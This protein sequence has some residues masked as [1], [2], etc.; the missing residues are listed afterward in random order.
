MTKH[1]IVRRTRRQAYQ[2]WIKALRGGKYRKDVDILKSRHGYCCLGVLCDL[3]TKDGGPKW[4]V[5]WEVDDVGL[6]APMRRFMGMTEVQMNTLANMNDGAGHYLHHPHSFKE[7]A[8]YIET[9]LL[10]KVKD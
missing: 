5:S 7:I 4:G 10:P 8:D 6:R 1:K 3:A 2:L 9:K